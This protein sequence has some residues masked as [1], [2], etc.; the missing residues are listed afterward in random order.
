[1]FRR[2]ATPRDLFSS[3]FRKPSE[4]S[5]GESPLAPEVGV[6]LAGCWRNAGAREQSDR[7]GTRPTFSGMQDR[8][9][10]AWALVRLICVKATEP[11]RQSQLIL[12]KIVIFFVSFSDFPRIPSFSRPSLK[13]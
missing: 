12:P 4:I 9:V 2:G 3:E 7:N 6:V 5:N 13:R 1:M 8:R 11:S 10:I